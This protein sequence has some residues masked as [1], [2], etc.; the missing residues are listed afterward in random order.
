MSTEIELKLQLSPKAASKLAK[1]PLLANIPT[2]RQ[3]LLNTYFDTP[4]L[5][6][7][8]RRVAVRFRKKGWQWLCTVKSAEPASGGLAMR[9]EWETQATPG[10]FDFGHVDN[11]EFRAFLEQRIAQLEPV[12]TT[13]FKRQIWHVPFGE[14]LIELAI[15]RGWIESR[16]QRLPICEIELELLSG[17]VDDIFWLTRQLQGDHHL[18]PAI[19]SKAERG[20]NLFL[21]TPLRPFKAKPPAVH[22]N[23]TPVEAFRCIALNCLEHFQRNEQGLLTSKDPEFVHQARVGLRRLRSAIKLFS[24]VLPP[25]FVTAYG[26]TWQTLATALGEARNW[27]VFLEETLP[28]I[29]AAFPDDKDIK[30][31]RKAAQHKAQSARKS[32]I[33]L[34]AIDE[35]PRL[36]LEFTAAVYT[37][38]EALP[39][40]LED[41]ARQQISRHARKARKLAIRH[42]E[43]TA[44]E[45]HKMRI[46]F[47]KLRYTLEFFAQLL[48]PRHLKPYLA[49]LS[50]LQDELGLI[51]DKVTAQSLCGEALHGRPAGP[52]HGWIA[53]QYALLVND[54]PVALQT[55]LAQRTP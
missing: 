11:A 36:L 26:Q 35:Y 15:D 39:I 1:H 8:K 23:Q 29:A 6:L 44:T 55:W 5:E 4:K 41:F 13:D 51:N 18:H 19:A 47:K 31:L 7:H 28:P 17:K 34:L 53:G 33:A 12:F 37:V 45:R 54:L 16:G 25:E 9:S 21:D 43:L 30:R 2:Q 38:S 14:S 42:A 50:R 22:A 3:H 32:V 20:Y 27:D 48:P 52:A 10:T 40:P 46:A 49:A 24:P